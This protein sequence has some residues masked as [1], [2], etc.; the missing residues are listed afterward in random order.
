MGGTFFF[1]IHG[2]G[3]GASPLDSGIAGRVIG[4]SIFRS[5]VVRG[6]R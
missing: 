3:M 6:L 5:T 1:L 2:V 4:S